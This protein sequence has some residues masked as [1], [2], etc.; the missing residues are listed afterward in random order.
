MRE[1]T[2]I[3]KEQKALIRKMFFGPY[4]DE[5][6]DSNGNVDNSDATIAKRLKLKKQTVSSMIAVMCE[7]HFKDVCESKEI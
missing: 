6:R 7:N 1:V 3:T 4:E 2:L 5:W